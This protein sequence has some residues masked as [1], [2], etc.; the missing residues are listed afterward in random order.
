MIKQDWL[1][2]AIEQAAAAIAAAL[3][4]GRAGQSEEAREAIENAWTSYVGIRREDFRVL[5]DATLRSMLG[6]KLPLAIRLLEA[7][8]ALAEARGA[9]READ[10]IRNRA[11]DLVKS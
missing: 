7:D 3:D 10:A 9:K 4:L 2:R 5:D 8:A 6:E 11:R 1:E